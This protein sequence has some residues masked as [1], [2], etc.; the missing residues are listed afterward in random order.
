MFMTSYHCYVKFKLKKYAKKYFFMVWNP[1]YNKR[2]TIYFFS[3]K[4]GF[5]NL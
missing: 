2:I 4:N 5:A 1:T 3:R